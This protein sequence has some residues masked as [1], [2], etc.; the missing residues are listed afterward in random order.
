MITLVAS[1]LKG[2]ILLHLGQCL[3]GVALELVPVG[4]RCS[5]E[6]SLGDIAGSPRRDF[7]ERSYFVKED[8]PVMLIRCGVT[9]R[10][11]NNRPIVFRAKHEVVGRAS[12]FLVGLRPSF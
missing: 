5:A 10:Y 9:I 4:R 1:G 6:V 7:A 11:S 2:P 12:T 3:V 8:L